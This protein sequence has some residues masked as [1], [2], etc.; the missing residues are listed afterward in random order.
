MSNKMTRPALGAPST[1]QR[2]TRSSWSTLWG[3]SGAREL[4]FIIEFH[5][6]KE[7]LQMKRV[8]LNQTSEE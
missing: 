2:G 3:V 8:Y 1:Q 6:N 4:A 7:T 5:L